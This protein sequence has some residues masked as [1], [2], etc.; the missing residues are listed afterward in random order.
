MR[1]LCSLLALALLVGCRA[2]TTTDCCPAP[3]RPEEITISAAVSLRDAFA[4]IGRRYEQRTGISVRFNF[5][6]SGVL[7]KQIEQGAPVD[8]FASA[9][10][11]QMDE[12]AVKSLIL[13]DTR[14][15]FARN[16]LVL[17]VSNNEAA[18]RPG[19]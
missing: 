11:R 2:H 7:Q 1:R 5:G 14:R 19:G 8:V 3:A 16:E 4:E 18:K 15:D 17:I 12:L 9:G 10:A 13:A 6:A